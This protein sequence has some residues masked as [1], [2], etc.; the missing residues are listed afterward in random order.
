LL[1]REAAGAS[2]LLDVRSQVA[3]QRIH[4]SRVAFCQ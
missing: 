1:L 4:A 2:E 3:G